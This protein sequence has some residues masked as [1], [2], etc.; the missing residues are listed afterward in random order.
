MARKTPEEYRRELESKKG[1]FRSSR[2]VEQKAEEYRIRYEAEL[3]DEAERYRDSDLVKEAGRTLA[4]FYIR[5]LIRNVPH[6]A[7]QEQISCSLYIRMTGEHI[8]YYDP[9]TKLN[10]AVAMR[11][12]KTDPEI[13]RELN[14]RFFTKHSHFIY[15]TKEGW[16]FE[17]ITDPDTLRAVFTAIVKVVEGF[18]RKGILDA[19]R[20]FP[21]DLDSSVSTT[22]IRPSGTMSYDTTITY[23]ARNR[24]F[25]PARK[26]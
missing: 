1:I 21:D 11:M 14:H 20:I 10:T 17:S 2:W 6:K 25:V 15:Y 5:E 22:G 13:V 26:I 16:R 3:E 4:E 9:S 12:E 19:E 7:D 23:T 24:H 18:V 8:W